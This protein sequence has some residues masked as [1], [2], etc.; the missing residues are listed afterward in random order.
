MIFDLP[1]TESIIIYVGLSIVFLGLIM[2]VI[3]FYQSLN[4]RFDKKEDKKKKP[5]PGCLYQVNL[6]LLICLLIASGFAILF[7]GAFIQSMTAFTKSALVA[8]VRCEKISSSDD[9]MKLT[10]IEKRG[11]YANQ[12]RDFMLIGDQWFVKGDII[13]WDNWLNFI[14]LHTMYKLNRVG[15]YYTNP[16]EQREKNPT[17]YSLVPK[18]DS[19]QWRWL[20]KNGYKLPL[21]SDVYGNSVYKYP[22][23][24]KIFKIYVTTSG[25]S[26]RT[27]N[28]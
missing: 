3:L 14:G 11:K 28:E 5:P 6:V 25:Y 15:G 4:R 1:F 12:A 10:L 18:E 2:F 17:Q 9:T 16:Y 22:E 7:F 27:E 13:K 8:E 20:Y 26:I 24:N 23:P 21:I 19:P